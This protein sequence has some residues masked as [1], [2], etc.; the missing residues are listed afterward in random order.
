MTTKQPT[1]FEEA[2][3]KTG[4][5]T[6]NYLLVLTCG[7]GLLGIGVDLFGFTLVVNTACDLHL[8]VSQKGVLTS[9]PFVGI[10]F[11]S[12]LWGYISDTRGRRFSLM[13][14]LLVAFVLSCLASLSPN[15]IFLGV[16][17]FVSVCF[18]CATNS[19]TYTI[20]GESCSQRV[21]KKCMVLMTCLLL[22]SPGIASVISYPV[23][24][25]GFASEIPLLGITFKPWRLLNIVLALPM[26]IAGVAMLFFYESPKFLANKGQNEDAL[27]IMKSIYAVN[28]KRAKEDFGIDVI[29]FNEATSR[30]DMPLLRAM[31]EQSAPLFRP[32][33]LW[34]TL[35]LFYI[36]SIVY[37]INN[38]LLVWL[39]HIMNLIKATM[40]VHADHAGSICS[41]I[42]AEE[43]ANLNKLATANSTEDIIISPEICLGTIDTNTIITMMVAQTIFAVLNL[44]ISYLPCQ[45][46]PIVLWILGLSALSGALL[47]L[48]PDPIASLFFFMTFTCTNL[49]M[50]I[51]ASYFVDLYPTS[52]RGMVACLSI[53][54]GRTSTFAGINIVGNIIFTHCNLTFYFGAFL[55]LTSAIAAWFLPPDKL[56]QSTTP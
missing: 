49:A 48:L 32:P 43:L 25:S 30:K 20:V 17:K 18:S 54:V 7:L 24:H 50:G 23:L 47:N 40:D 35:Q 51:L 22:L 19:V 27:E 41:L 53:M 21:R 31:Y 8:S 9:L 36:V 45:R 1:P 11:V 14:S 6:Y 16:I 5:G 2:L 26:G 52:C 33:L 3:D 10:L 12:Y 28:H 37:L 55:V 29:V 39:P 38:T 15:G 46:R 4:T 42:S 34:R 44:I 13:V 56:I